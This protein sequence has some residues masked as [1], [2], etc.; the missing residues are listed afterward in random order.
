MEDPAHFFSRPDPVRD[1]IISVHCQV[2]ECEAVFMLEDLRVQFA[3]PAN[4][5]LLFLSPESALG[6]HVRFL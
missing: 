5:G 1:E 4:V 2:P 3:D 6:K